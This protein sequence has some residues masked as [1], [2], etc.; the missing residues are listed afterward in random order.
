MFQVVRKAWFGNMHNIKEV[1]NDFTNQV[2]IELKQYLNNLKQNFFEEGN[3]KEKIANMDSLQAFS[4]LFTL[5]NNLKKE[6]SQRLPGTDVFIKFSDLTMNVFT[7][8]QKDEIMRLVFLLI[9]SLA[10]MKAIETSD[11]KVLKYLG[12]GNAIKCIINEE[13]TKAMSFQNLNG[14]QPVAKGKHFQ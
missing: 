6:A 10:P 13:E 7:I 8:I 14:K 12:F 9:L 5:L 2:I 1:T 3:I 4:H 11:V